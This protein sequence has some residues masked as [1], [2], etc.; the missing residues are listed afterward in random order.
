MKGRNWRRQLPWL[1]YMFPGVTGVFLF[2]IRPFVFVIRDAFSVNAVRYEW[3]G[4]RNFIELFS[5]HAF[6]LA[7]SH[8]ALIAAGGIVCMLPLALFLALLIDR[9]RYTNAD[10]ESILMMPF[11]LPA[12]AVAILAELLISQRVLY[13]GSLWMVF[14]LF[15]WKYTGYFVLLFSEGLGHVPEELSES[16]RMEG[17]GGLYLFFHVQLP[18][19]SPAIFFSVLLS[20]MSSFRMF[21]EVYLL[22]GDHPQESVY[23]LSHFLNNAMRKMNYPKMSAAAVVVEFLIMVVMFLLLYTEKQISNG[24]E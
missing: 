23:L 14:L 3:A 9:H 2:Y 22:Y 6:L 10:T 21:R 5:N 16:A 4:L 18:F 15:L 19:L 1:L 8:T 17:A 12:A 7:L 24:L 20:I 11:V 13:R